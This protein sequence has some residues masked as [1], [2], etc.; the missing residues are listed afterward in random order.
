MEMVRAAYEDGRS[1][2]FGA[3]AELSTD[4]IVLCRPEPTR[5]RYLWGEKRELVGRLAR[6]PGRLLQS[7]DGVH[8]RGRRQG[9]LW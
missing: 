3:L 1:G 8:R 5:R 2:R 6:A 9:I 7:C 4:E